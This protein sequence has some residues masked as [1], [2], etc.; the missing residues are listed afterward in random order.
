MAEGRGAGVGFHLAGNVSDVKSELP[1]RP[2]VKEPTDVVHDAGG[3]IMPIMEE[4]D[5][6][7][8]EEELEQAEAA[9]RKAE[10]RH[11]NQGGSAETRRDS[12]AV[13]EQVPTMRSTKADEELKCMWIMHSCGTVGVTRKRRW[14]WDGSVRARCCSRT[15]S[16]A[17][18]RA[19]TW[20]STRS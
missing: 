13:Q 7:E 1:I 17:K 10:V 3:E 5:E 19:R 16:R 14:L 15:S 20:W 12:P 4:S 6:K 2:E 18:G 8:I 11:S 9:H